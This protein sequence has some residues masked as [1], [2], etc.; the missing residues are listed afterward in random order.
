MNKHLPV[1]IT[2]LTFGSFGLV[3]DD[4]IV[5]LED[6][7]ECCELKP[8][9]INLKSQSPI[10][11]ISM[12]G[13][14]TARIIGDMKNTITGSAELT[15][16]REVTDER[17]TIELGTFGIL[18]DEKCIEDF[19]SNIKKCE[20]PDPFIIELNKPL[21]FFDGSELDYI[22]IHKSV[23]KI[24][25]LWGFARGSSSHNL[26]R[27]ANANEDFK[28]K[29][30]YEF[31]ESGNWNLDG[32]FSVIVPGS[33]AFKEIY[34]VSEVEP[35][36][37]TITYLEY[38]D[39]FLE[40]KEDKRIEKCLIEGIKKYDPYKGELVQI[41]ESKECNDFEIKL[42]MSN[43]GTNLPSTSLKYQR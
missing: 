11:G 22:S 7:E 26:Y 30:L 13:Y 18:P 21:K 32:S 37:W 43:S 2:L 24:V 27:L 33:A 5:V 10:D 3:G 35:D 42:E 19:F 25:N 29:F 36:E 9:I 28:A 31:P 38:G 41:E 20:L 1:L 34:T 39:S 14:L 6:T 12:E 8:Y 17:I 40:E 23:L 15:F 4:E 16:I